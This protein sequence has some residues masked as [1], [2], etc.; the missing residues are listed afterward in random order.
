MRPSSECTYN[1]NNSAIVLRVV[2]VDGLDKGEGG[3]E[4]GDP[5][6]ESEAQGQ[7]AP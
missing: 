1:T 7:G 4:E 6:Q 5:A 2:G 3:E